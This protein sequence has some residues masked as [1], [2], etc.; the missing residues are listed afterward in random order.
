MK[1]FFPALLVLAAGLR[2]A[3]FWDQ[4]KYSQWTQQEVQTLMNDSPWARIIEIMTEGGRAGL[5]KGGGDHR[6]SIGDPSREVSG[7]G[8]VNVLVR[9]HS[10]LP[11][12]QA[13][14]RARFGDKVLESPEAAQMLA[15]PETSYV[16][17][18]VGPPRFMP[19]ET[20]GLKEQASLVVKGRDPI[21][22]E[23][24]I[25]DRGQAGAAVIFF[26]P[27]GAKPIQLEDEYVELRLKFPGFAL[28]RRFKLKEMV[29]QGK[30]EI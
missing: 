13:V 1:R 21:R 19:T 23:N 17:A 12:K 3:D 20:A 22:A 9:F 4:K 26:F 10:A 24:V 7:A 18:V 29:F 2:A 25:I 16:I 8:R 11:L 27:R 30:L 28:N 15:Q 14:I 5:A 6:S